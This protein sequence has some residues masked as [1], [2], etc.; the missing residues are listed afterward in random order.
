[1]SPPIRKPMTLTQKILAHHARGLTRPWVEAGDILQISVDWTIASELAWNGMDRTYS[2][3]GR[4][5]VHDKTRFFLAVDHTVDPVTLATDPRAQKL[6]QLSRDFA[7][8]QS[9]RHFY[10]ANVTILH[11]KFYRDLVQP[12]QVVLGA[13]SHTSS[14]GGLGAVSIGLGGADITAAMVLGQSWIEVPEA[15][16]VDYSGVLPFGIG[17]KD[18]ILKTL[19]DLGRNTVAMERTVEY[20]GDV[21]HGWSTDLRFTIANMTAEFGGLNGIFEAD[22][23]VAAWLADRKDENKG[24]LYFRADDDAPYA[25]RYKIDLGRLGPLVAKPFSP[26]N[27][28][29]V[30]QALGTVLD[31]CFIGAC[32]TTEEELVLGALVLEQAFKDRPARAAH[33]KLLVVPGDQSI[34]RRM[35]QGELWKHYEKAGFRIG[36][37]GCS[38]CLGVASEKASPGETWLSSQNRNFENRMGQ[39]SFAWLASAATVAAS[40]VEMKIADPRAYLGQIDQQRYERLLFRDSK[41]PLPEVR[42]VEPTVAVVASAAA[43]SQGGS[44]QGKQVQGRVQRFGDAVDTDAIIPGAFCHLTQLEELGQKAFHYVRPEFFTLAQAGRNV[45]VAGE[46]WGSG[47]SREQAVWALIGAGITAVIARSYAFIHKRNLVN[48][49]LSY[50]VVKDPAFYELAQEDTAVS[51]DFKAGT[52]S[53]AG[54]TFSAEVPS[55]IVQALAREGGLVPAIKRHGK[56]VFEALSS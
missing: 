3:L 20:R 19:G 44:V 31:G 36:L 32:T 2:L 17:G 35:Q 10:D 18:V 42:S 38:M 13:D 23:T 9:I 41:R 55:A 1:M 56:Q 26:D 33:P 45:L 54:K 11:T 6:T 27:V 40:S 39:G 51:I 14:H 30:E 52:V 46:G 16:A 8:E 53:V 15:I 49:A 4:P 37:P 28:M 24:T 47:S 22:P 50:L 21:T 34:Q 7:K 25:H 29:P 43:A 12:G 48:E 5:A